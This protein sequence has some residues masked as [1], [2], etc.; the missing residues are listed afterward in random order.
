MYQVSKYFGFDTIV[1]SSLAKARRRRGDAL[2]A[3]MPRLDG[4]ER[5]QAHTPR[6]NT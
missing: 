5:A 3:G 2:P 1:A 4:A 6:K